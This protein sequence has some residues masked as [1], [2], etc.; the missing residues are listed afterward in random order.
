MRKALATIA[1]LTLL[2]GAT[3]ADTLY[4]KNGSVLKG[5][6]LGY[7]NGQFIFELN[8]G[9]R[10]QFRPNEVSR[11]VI[12]RDLANE[13]RRDSD[14]NN[15][16]NDPNPPRGESESAAPFDVRL[17]DQW[18]RSPIQVSRGQRIRVNASGTVYLEGRT[19]TGPDGLEGRRDPDSPLP[20]ENDGALVA[21]IG[22]DANSPAIL[23]GRSREFR[24]D[25]DGLLYFTVNHWETRDARGAFRVNVSVDR[26]AGGGND[27]VADSPNRGREKTITVYADQS[28]TDTGIDVEPNMTFEITAEGEIEI[29][30]GLR[31]G[32]DGNRQANVRDANYP[33]QNEGA[34]ALIAKIRYREG[35]DSNFVFV[36]SRANPATEPNE[37]GRLYL[38]INDAYFRDNKG[39][40]TV[41]IRW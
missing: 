28:W 18:I 17:E 19:Q 29:G 41:R 34:G 14:R 13:D 11:L 35:R 30:K 37:Y 36:G 15:P 21:A 22:R 20:S 32:P 39:S 38:G 5:V 31:S 24:A 10:L 26:N 33:L 40:F 1:V 25:R 9:N 27:G 8:N 7:E 6:F 2:A 12:E 16:R 4:L 23:I 3:L